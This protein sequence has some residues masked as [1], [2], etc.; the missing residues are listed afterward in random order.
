MLS[1]TPVS[2][3]V[4]GPRKLSHCLQEHR[5]LAPTCDRLSSVSTVLQR[6]PISLRGARRLTAVHPAAAVR[7]CRRSAWAP[8]PRA[9]PA[10]RAEV[11]W[12]FALHG[13][14]PL[15]LCVSPPPGFST[16]PTTAC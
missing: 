12:Q 4:C 7:H 15:I 1:R 16:I 10:S 13:L 9:R 3:F 2:T 8:A 11:H 6:V 5:N 14:D